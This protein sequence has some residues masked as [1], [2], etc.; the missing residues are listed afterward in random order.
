MQIAC[1]PH[2]SSSIFIA[3]THYRRRWANRNGNNPLPNIVEEKGR[4]TINWRARSRQ[5]WKG[6]DLTGL[7]HTPHAR[8]APNITQIAPEI[9]TAPRPTDAYLPT[10]LS[11]SMTF[12]CGRWRYRCPFPRRGV[13]GRLMPVVMGTVHRTSPNE[14]CTF[15]FCLFSPENRPRQP[16]DGVCVV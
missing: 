15:A 2:Q 11:I 6:V 16:V 12:P 13:G 9:K 1:S 7:P 14:G 10:P 8:H 5:R 3:T 4:R